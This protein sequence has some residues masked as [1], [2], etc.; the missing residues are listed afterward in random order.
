MLR[1]K[2]CVLRIGDF[3]GA[4]PEGIGDLHGMSGTFIGQAD[5]IAHNEAACRDSH[6]TQYASVAQID[7]PLGRPAGLLPAFCFVGRERPAI[8]RD[9][10]LLGIALFRDDGFNRCGGRVE[11]GFGIGVHVGVLLEQFATPPR[12]GLDAFR[13]CDFRPRSVERGNEVNPRD[14]PVP[15]FLIKAHVVMAFA[16]HL[17]QLRGIGVEL[18]GRQQVVVAL[19]TM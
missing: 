8:A 11:N 6:Q 19:Q 12:G 9:R 13:T 16:Q 4:H 2:A 14:Q 3:A 10:W 18:H 15:C 1:F 5:G 7:C 17:H